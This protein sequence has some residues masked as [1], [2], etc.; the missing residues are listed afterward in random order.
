M[1]QVFISYD[2]GDGG[3]AAKVAAAIEKAG[4]SAWY[5]GRDSVPGPAYLIQVRREIEKSR[6]FVLIISR[7]SLRS[8]Q[9]TNEVVAAYEK[10][11]FFLP[12]LSGLTHTEF[13][14][15]P[16]ENAQLVRQCLGAATSLRLPAHEG[17]FL[18]VAERIVAG[19]R[20]LGLE[21]HRRREESQVPLGGGETA[22]RAVLRETIMARERIR[23]TGALLALEG[24]IDLGRGYCVFK[25]RHY[26]REVKL[27]KAGLEM[28]L[29]EPGE[30]HM[31]S[32]ESEEGRS[33]H[34]GPRH[35]VRI[36]RPFY[37]GKHEVTQRHYESVMGANPGYFK[38]NDNPIEQVSWN[39]A[40]EFCRRLGPGFRL[41]TEAEWEYA[42]RAGTT[43]PFCF[44]DSISTDQANYNGHYAY[45]KK[46][47]GV[48][49]AMTMPVGSFQPN[50]GGLHDMHGNVWEWCED[51]WHDTY[52]GA[53]DDGSVW[54]EGGSQGLRVC[55][56]GAWNCPPRRL[57]SADRC[58][59]ASS[60]T[61]YFFGFR[62]AWALE[63]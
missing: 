17:E 21:P 61:D 1:S 48:Y 57:R 14:A 59:C 27:D 51:V 10:K 5:Y 62:V 56:G 8:H 53:P 47:K 55:R 29:V 41:P 50:A 36:S 22:E 4:Y 35:H 13:Q 32:P 43:T 20:S 60:Y 25:G 58:W 18:R 52:A 45:G 9:V 63:E 39:D 12:L 31:G 28:L 19:L 44:G 49:R 30:F 3:L 33:Q 2:E 37:L 26:P 7:P 42:C 40:K 16:D 24:L 54:G 46:G 15:L 11:K 23:E 34:E 6:V 38:G